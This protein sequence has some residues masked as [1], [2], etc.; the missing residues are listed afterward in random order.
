LQA[1]KLEKLLE[2]EYFEMLLKHITKLNLILFILAIRVLIE[3][4][5]INSLFD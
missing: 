5:M 2:I 1:K 3:L 4:E